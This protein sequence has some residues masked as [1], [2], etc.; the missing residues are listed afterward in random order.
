MPVFQPH[1]TRVP[2]RTSQY[3]AFPNK[4]EEKTTMMWTSLNIVVFSAALLEMQG[5]VTCDTKTRN[6]QLKNERHRLYLRQ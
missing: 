6:M 2:Y 3:I 5:I 1:I 4:A